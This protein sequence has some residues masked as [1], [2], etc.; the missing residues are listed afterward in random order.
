MTYTKSNSTI[1]ALYLIFFLDGF[2]VGL[3]FP[4]FSKLLQ[5]P[6][7]DTIKEL[8]T[9]DLIPLFFGLLIGSFS[10]AQFVGMK[11]FVFY[12]NRIRLKA[13]L[14]WSIFLMAV[15]FMISGIGVETN[16][17]SLLFFG[18]LFTG[19]FSANIVLCLFPK[20]SSITHPEKVFFYH[21][22]L[23]AI[24]LYALMLGVLIGGVSSDPSLFYSAT[25]A[26]PFWI[27]T[28]FSLSIL[29]FSMF[30]IPNG[31]KEKMIIHLPYSPLIFWKDESIESHRPIYFI[32]FFFLLGWLAFLQFSSLYF[33]R[34]FQSPPLFITA[35]LAGMTIS[36]LAAYNVFAKTYLKFFS[37]RGY[38]FLC[39]STSIIYQILL[40][41]VTNLYVA[42]L[43]HIALAASAG[44]MLKG[45]SEKLTFHSGLIH[46]KLLFLRASFAILATFITPIFGG[47]FA[48]YSITSIFLY[49]TIC[50]LI[51]LIFSLIK[52][53]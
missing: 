5:T 48:L 51:S 3:V 16:S 43:L 18:R 33:V 1:W 44:L 40:L 36:V 37:P 38:F 17:Y 30:T 15:G 49:V 46:S 52:S 24:S 50:F 10:L 39:L 21:E 12:V 53:N 9:F 41:Y 34:V 29:A 26:T 31:E 19:F 47:I 20:I 22:K 4:L 35:T 27:T 7:F 14:L 45:L 32:F 13:I 28:F 8:S 2:G 25:Y 42:S 11:V 23:T 6:L